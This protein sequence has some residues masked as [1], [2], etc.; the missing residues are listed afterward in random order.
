NVSVVDWNAMITLNPK[1]FAFDKLHLQPVGYRARASLYIELA[2]NLWNV[3]MPT[4]TTSTTT[5]TTTTVVG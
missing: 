4:T 5:T 2:Q 1:W 3:V